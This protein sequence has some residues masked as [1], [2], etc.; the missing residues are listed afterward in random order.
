M[1]QVAAQAVERR[2]M[3]QQDRPTKTVFA[4]T[5]NS[6]KSCMTNN[7]SILQNTYFLPRRT[8]F[9][10]CLCYNFPM[11]I[12]PTHTSTLSYSIILSLE[13]GGMRNGVIFLMDPPAQIILFQS[14]CFQSKCLRMPWTGHFII[15]PDSYLQMQFE[16]MEHL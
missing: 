11:Y 5:V 2:P 7:H 15:L 16:L 1:H 9:L 3:P 12:C 13:P 6:A 8:F 4:L 10:L 14:N